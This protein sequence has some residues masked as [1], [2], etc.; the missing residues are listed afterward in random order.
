M[1]DISAGPY[2]EVDGSDS[3]FFD[4]DNRAVANAVLRCLPAHRQ[5]RDMHAGCERVWW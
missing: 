1:Q 5:A 3:A 4:D 2:V